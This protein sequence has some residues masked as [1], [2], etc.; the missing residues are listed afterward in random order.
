IWALT[1]G[2]C[3][4]ENASSPALSALLNASSHCFMSA[5]TG[6]LGITTGVCARAVVGARNAAETNTMS[7][8]RETYDRCGIMS[9]GCGCAAGWGRVEFMIE[10]R[11]Q[12]AT[13]A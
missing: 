11:G 9:S 5:P 6:E 7:A 13:R 4:L 3:A 8:K 12:V 1:R 10:P 2:K